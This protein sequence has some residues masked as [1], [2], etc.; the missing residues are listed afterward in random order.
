MTQINLPYSHFRKI[1]KCLDNK[2]L[3][4]QI[5][6]SRQVY[7]QNKF[8]FGG[9][10]NPAPYRMWEGY[11][12]ALSLYIIEMYKEWQIRFINGSRGGKI[13]HAAGEYILNTV[14]LSGEIEMPR[15]I[16]DERIF[17]SYRSAL[18][19]KDFKWYSQFGWSEVPTIPIKID[20]KGNVTLPYFY[21]N[22][23]NN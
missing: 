13:N 19:Y 22:G 1:A 4:K 18:L 2:R 5:T 6:E 14:D 8:G 12:D 3:N 15:W 23:K 21:S 11:D 20:K 17:S 9:Q 16:N 7:T 10:G